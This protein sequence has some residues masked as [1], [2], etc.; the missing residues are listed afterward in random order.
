MYLL[1]LDPTGIGVARLR[2]VVDFFFSHCVYRM[3]CAVLL[4]G[5]SRVGYAC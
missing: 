3:C 5:D 4:C 2:V 1:T